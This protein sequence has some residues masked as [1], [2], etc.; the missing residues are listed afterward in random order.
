VSGLGLPVKLV[1]TAGQEAD[2]THAG[3]LIEGVPAQAVIAD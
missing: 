1:L 2:V 3:K